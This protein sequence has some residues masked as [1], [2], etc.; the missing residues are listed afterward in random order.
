MVAPGIPV[1]YIGH[2][3]RD[4][5][6]PLFAVLTIGEDVI[7]REQERSLRHGRRRITDM[8]LAAADAPPAGPQYLPRPEICRTI[9]RATINA[10]RRQ[11]RHRVNTKACSTNGMPDRR[12]RWICAATS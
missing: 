4:C 11:S 6:G 10:E 3:D 5:E 8:A 2:V 7:N 12:S 1:P 9:S